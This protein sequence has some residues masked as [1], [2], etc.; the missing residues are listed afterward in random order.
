VSW[1]GMSE[2]GDWN[3]RGGKVER[4]GRESRT[5]GLGWER[6]ML[7]ILVYAL[8]RCSCGREWSEWN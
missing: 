3:E 1:S 5:S 4:A 2:V 7:I 6:R 8:R